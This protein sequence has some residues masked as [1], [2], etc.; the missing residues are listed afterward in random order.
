MPNLASG[1]LA[2]FYYPLTPPCPHTWT[3][4]SNHFNNYLV[5]WETCSVWQTQWSAWSVSVP[6]R[7]CL[8]E[9][10]QQEGLIWV[11]S[12]HITHSGTLSPLYTLLLLSHTFPSLAGTSSL[13]SEPPLLRL[14]EKILPL[15]SQS[16]CKW[17][18]RRR[19]QRVWQERWIRV[20][21]ER[22]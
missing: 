4:W 10:N 18:N 16:K 19:R 8:W 15:V 6:R 1:P 22:S 2:T 17:H 3:S 21:L 12:Q 5:L 20:C 7:L 9:D 11:Y 13:S 14:R